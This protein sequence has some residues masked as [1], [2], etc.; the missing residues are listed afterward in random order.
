MARSNARPARQLHMNS[1]TLKLDSGVIVF[2]ADLFAG[3]GEQPTAD[4]FRPREWEDRELVTS[5]QRGRGTALV[6]DTPVGRAVLR[7]Y[8]RG[9]WAARFIRSRYLFTGYHRSRPVREFHILEQL[10]ALGLPSPHPVAALCERHGIACTGALMTLEIE[11]T[12][13]LEQVLDRLQSEAWRA[14]GACIRRFHDHGLVHA[15]LTVRNILFQEGGRFFLVD[16]DRARFSKQNSAAFRANL[17]RF[18]RSLVKTWLEK[19]EDMDQRAWTH[20]LQG[21]EHSTRGD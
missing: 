17:Q 7:Q 13:P 9:G 10:A 3:A 8:L 4:W 18:R 1:R 2:D 15:D 14:V 6:I 12:R 20:L 19:D 21:Y 11:N 16:F 5:K